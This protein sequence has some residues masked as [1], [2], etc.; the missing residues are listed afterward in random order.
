VGDKPAEVDPWI[1]AGDC[2]HES[3]GLD[4]SRVRDALRPR[5]WNAEEKSMA[6]ARDDRTLHA[7]IVSWSY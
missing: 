5:K 1:P 4:R 3:S 6:K 2:E 7:D